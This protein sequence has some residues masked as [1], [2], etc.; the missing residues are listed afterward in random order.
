MK[1]L[2][3]SEM[4]CANV[5]ELRRTGL[6]HKVGGEFLHSKG[7]HRARS[8]WRLQPHAGAYTAPTLIVTPLLSL[9]PSAF[10]SQ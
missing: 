3:M 2:P 9:P 7:S 10:R 4:V 6:A 5:F 1:S 8:S